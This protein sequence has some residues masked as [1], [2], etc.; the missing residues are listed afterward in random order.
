MSILVPQWHVLCANKIHLLK[1]HYILTLI[2]FFYDIA[3]GCEPQKKAGRMKD[4]IGT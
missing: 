4:H 1:Q 2:S 3:L